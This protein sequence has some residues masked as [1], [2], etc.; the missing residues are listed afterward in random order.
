[1]FVHCLFF[2][3]N[4]K[5]PEQYRVHHDDKNRQFIIQLNPN[6]KSVI[7]NLIYEFEMVE[8]EVSSI[9][10]LS[11]NVPKDY[12]GKGI[13]KLLAN[14][15][16]DYCANNDLQMTLTCW[17]LEGYLQRNPNPRYNSLVKEK[18]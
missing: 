4:T 3:S 17:Y 15:A 1:M 10:L 14:A 13:A 12:E 5:F 9:N 6:D 8:K 7:A 16:L 11:T 18:M 2:C